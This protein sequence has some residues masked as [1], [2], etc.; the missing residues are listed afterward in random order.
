MQDKAEKTATAR[1]VLV[2]ANPF[3]Y[4]PGSAL[5]SYYRRGWSFE[6]LPFSESEAEQI[7]SI[8]SS[9][10]VHTRQEATESIFL[11]QAAKQRVLH[12]ASHAYVDS[13]LDAFSG[14]ILAADSASND[15]GLLM[16]Y[17]I[18]SLEL[19]CDLVTLSACETGQGQLHEGEG[20]LGLPRL[21]F[22]AGVNSVLMTLWQV[23][24]EFA[25]ELMPE[26]Y[27]LFLEHNLSKA[28]AL[29]KAKW[30]KLSEKKNSSNLY[31]QH[32]F[33]WASFVLYG[34]PGMNHTL[35]SP[36]IEFAFIALVILAT[37]FAFYLRYTH[38]PPLIALSKW[39]RFNDNF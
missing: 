11:E 4:G 26:F 31:Y 32:P 2:L 36:A 13:S 22:S 19:N 35:V 28:D 38:R 21:F 15:D 14:I 29:A 18:A 37:V 17:E 1:G 34:D 20:V 8:H 5:P 7:K 12:I 30:A 25:S 33:Y 23:H 39:R 16:G 27:R 24:D 3:D 9:A 6:A 10:A